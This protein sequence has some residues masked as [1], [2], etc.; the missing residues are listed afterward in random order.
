MQSHPKLIELRPYRSLLNSDFD[1][2]KLSLAEIPTITEQLEVRVDR[3]VPDINQYSLLHAK[4]YA[5]HNHLLGESDETESVFF[6][7]QELNVQKF[8]VESITN[9]FSKTIL[10]KVPLQQERSSGDY[11]ISMKFASEKIAVVADGM[12]YLYVLDRGCRDVDDKWKVVFS[13]DVTG[14]GEKFIISDVVYKEA[15]KPELH[16]LLTSVKQRGTNERYSTILHWIT[17]EKSDSWNQMALR[18]LTVNSFVQYANFERSCDAIYIVSDDGCKFTLDSENEIKETPEIQK[19]E[20]KYKWTQ[21]REDLTIKFPLPESFKKNL[22]AVDTQETHIRV[23]YENETLLEGHLYQRIDADVTCW[24]IESNTNTLVLTLE[25]C[26]GGLMWP[27]IVKGDIFGEYV[28][29]PALVGEISER[30][31]PL[32]SDTETAPPTG[33]TFNSQQV[34]ECD[35][36]CDKLTIFERI[37]RDSHEVTH[38]VSLGS[39]QV[40]LTVNLEKGLPLAIGSRSDVDVCIWQP[41]QDDG[42]RLV[43]KGTLLAL[44]YIQVGKKMFNVKLISGLSL[45]GN[46][47]TIKRKCAIFFIFLLY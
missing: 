6:I 27:E 9:T 4:L 19:N 26:E 41:K 24:S 37:S 21:T 46:W 30:L 22:V 32:T 3:L 28:P 11:N 20:K 44:G 31:A 18:E 34:E 36:E 8:S 12:G 2:Y 47:G 45:L 7:D 40:L 16:L 15:T 5:L 13:G 1:G 38:K 10:W 25:K 43:H 39:H 29:E 33:T 14:P 35:F 17:L 42:F 23:K